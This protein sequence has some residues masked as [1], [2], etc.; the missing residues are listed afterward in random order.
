MHG[1]PRQLHHNGRLAVLYYDDEILAANGASTDDTDGLVNL[2]L[3][4]RDVL[5]V[6]LVRKQT[7]TQYRVS[8]RSKGD[9]SVRSVAVQFGGGGHVNAAACSIPGSREAVTGDVVTRVGL[10]L[11]PV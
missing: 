4:A 6:A 11:P 1:R 3:G 8:M 2:P 9:V 5:A 10:Q 7:D